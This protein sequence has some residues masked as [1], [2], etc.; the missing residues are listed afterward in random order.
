MSDAIE[1]R[2]WPKIFAERGIG[3][4][5]TRWEESAPGCWVGVDWMGDGVSH[6]V[7][8][9]VSGLCVAARAPREGVR[10]GQP[11]AHH[12]LAMADALADMI[13]ARGL[14]VTCAVPDCE[15][16]RWPCPTRVAYAVVPLPSL[17]EWAASPSTATDP[18]AL[19][20]LGVRPVTGD[21]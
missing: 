8:D 3:D 11:S 6:V 20:P 19:R 16:A 13:R 4:L 15:H 10:S 7:T 9:D 17:G 2:D 5:L 1:T 12:W 18:A 14:G 21:G